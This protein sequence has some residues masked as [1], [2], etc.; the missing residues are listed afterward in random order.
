MPV[1][2]DE[3]TSLVCVGDETSNVE[4]I[5]RFSKLTSLLLSDNQLSSIDLS[6]NP[7]LIRLWISNNPLSSATI[8][9]LDSMNG[10][11]GLQ[12]LR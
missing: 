5:G 11:Y 1:R 8:D 6:N 2:V 12:I 10:V 3:V 4:G 7:A 9:Y